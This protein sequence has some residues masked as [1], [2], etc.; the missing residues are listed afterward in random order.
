MTEF[1]GAEDKVKFD[2]NTLLVECEDNEY[3]YISGLE[4][5]KFET[6][7]KIL[8]YTSLMGNNL[9]PYAIMI[10]ERYTYFLYHR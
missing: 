8:D 7:D 9:T 2:G 10:G 4:V 5:T 3:I 1:S 6:D